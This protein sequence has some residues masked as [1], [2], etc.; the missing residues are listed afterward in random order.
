LVFE[1]PDPIA[2]LVFLAPVLP[3]DRAGTYADPHET[4]PHSIDGSAPP[5][6]ESGAASM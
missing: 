4:E 5:L 3:D 2:V 1:K 6:Q